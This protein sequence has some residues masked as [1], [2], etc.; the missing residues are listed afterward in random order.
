MFP[1]TGEASAAAS[2]AAAAGAR[3]HPASAWVEPPGRRE[4]KDLEK[5]DYMF[6]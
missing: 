4:G 1:S 3:A 5:L 6:A 2:I